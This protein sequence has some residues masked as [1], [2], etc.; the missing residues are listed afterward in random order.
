MAFIHSELMKLKLT[1]DLKEEDVKEGGELDVSKVFA[2]SCIFL[3]ALIH[4]D[5]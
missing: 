3:Q 2:K 1:L 4:L 5:Q